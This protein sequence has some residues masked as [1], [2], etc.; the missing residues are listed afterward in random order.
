[1]LANIVDHLAFLYGQDEVS[2]LATRIDQLIHNHFPA[3]VA[4]PA[5]TPRQLPLTQRDSLLITY[6]DQVQRE[7]ETPLRTLHGFLQRHAAEVVNSVHILPFYPFTSDDGFSVIDYREV[8]PQL[9]SWADVRALGQTFKLMFDAVV[10]HCSV[11]NSWFQ[12]FLQGESPYKDW[13][14]VVEGDPDLS[15]VTRPR[16]LPLLTTFDTAEGPKKVW[17]TFSADQVDLDIRNPEVLLALLDVL[18]F[19][20]AHGARYIRL[21]AIAYLWKEI[22]TTCIHLPQTHRAVQLMRSVLDCVAPDVMLIT[23]TNVPHQDNISY[24]GNGSNEAQLVYNFTLPPLL[25]HSIATGNAEALSEWARSLNVPSS[26]VTFFNFIASHDGIGVFPLKSILSNEQIDALAD[27]VLAHGGFVSYRNLPD[28]SQT[29]YELNISY[30]DALS[31]PSASEPIGSQVDRFLV[32]HAI[33]MA[34]AGVPGIYFHSLFGSRSDRQAVQA[35]G[36]NRRINRQKLTCAGLEQDL[37]DP[38]SLR[39]QV[40]S[41]FQRLMGLRSSSTAFDPCGPQEVLRIDP[42]I[43]A[44]VRTSP[45]GAQSALCLHNLSSEAVDVSAPLDDKLQPLVERHGVVNRGRLDL[46][47]QPYEARWLLSEATGS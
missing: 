36:I 12:G 5:R 21:D 30:F 9:G 38:S 37:A 1:M 46:R 26:G 45:D 39:S 10:N 16:A 3:A 44:L 29:P 8:D 34:M 22:G 40:L 28:G 47:L 43:F 18:L 31:N 14:I 41:G 42:R 20:V 32:V 7:G 35:S 13:F 6:G 4:R 24:F 33:Q 11:K 27:R 15:L 23:E 25:L 19:Y 17:T 2:A